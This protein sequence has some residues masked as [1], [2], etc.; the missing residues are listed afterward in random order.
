M[1]RPR[2]DYQLS[3]SVGSNRNIPLI[4]ILESNALHFKSIVSGVGTTEICTPFSNLISGSRAA[5]NVKFA[6]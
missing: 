5:R 1:I 6:G 2:V 4:R 3:G